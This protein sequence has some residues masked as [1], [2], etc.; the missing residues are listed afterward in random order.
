M[1]LADRIAVFMDGRIVQVGTPR[2]I[3]ATPATTAVAGFI[4]TP[5]M[6]LLPGTWQGRTVTVGNAVLPV[7]QAAAAPTPVVLGVRPADLSVADQ[8]IAATV[9]R[10][11]DLGDSSIVSFRD[12]DRRLVK[13]KHD[14]PPAVR[15]GD[16]VC[17]AFAPDAAHLFD[18]A[19]GRRL[20][21]A[22]TAAAT[23][24]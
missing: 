13:L 11:E 16:V 23:H 15:E 4:G 1:T 14:R 2:A 21:M 19:G 24:A 22:G 18:P 6:N 3:Y 7:A 17:L 8:G 5:P 9:E 10:V 12:A 20:G